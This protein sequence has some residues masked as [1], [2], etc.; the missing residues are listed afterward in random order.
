[1][2]LAANAHSIGIKDVRSLS[3]VASLLGV[4]RK[5]LQ[6]ILYVVPEDKRYLSFTIPKRRGGSRTISTPRRELKFFQRQLVI[7][8]SEVYKPRQ[9]VTGFCLGRSIVT[10]A[11]KHSPSRSYVF[12]VD[13]K[14]FFASI[15]FGRIRG[16]FINQPFDLPAK[17]ATVLAQICCHKNALPQGAPTSPILSNMICSRLD[18]RLTQLAKKHGCL[19][20][21]YADDITFSKRKSDFP[22]EIGYDT[23][24]GAKAGTELIKAVQENGFEINSDKVYLQSNKRRQRVTGL[25]VNAKPNVPRRF[26]RQIRAMIHDWKVNG[27][28]HASAAHHKVYRRTGRS[29]VKPELRDIVRGKL[30]FVKMVKGP[31]DAVYKN[32]QARFVKVEP[33]YI[34]VMQKENSS[35]LQRDFFISHASEDKAAIAKPLA[36]ALIASGYSVWYDEYELRLGDSLLQKINEGLAHSE[37]GVVILS[38]NFFAKRWTQKELDG[39]TALETA[40]GKKK[41]IP[42][43]HKM[44]LKEVSKASPMLAGL[45]A[46]DTSKHSVSEIVSELKNLL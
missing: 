31:S 36:D 1:M 29:S 2:G 30:D 37:F 7:H 23:P 41:V 33:S 19:Y 26:I 39:L 14:D 8:L 32:L 35:L 40:G 17:A 24:D 4:S 46:A 45:K 25:V 9:A 5:Q 42:I 43:W 44:T 3:D 22:V 16:L 38:K 15:N 18:G 12:N 20:S 13:L 27:Y 11:Q 28:E 10:N 34:D 21:R 6:Y